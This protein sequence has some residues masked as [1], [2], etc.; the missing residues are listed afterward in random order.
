MPR[1]ARAALCGSGGKFRAME[2]SGMPVGGSLASS[3]AVAVDNAAAQQRNTAAKL[4]ARGFTSVRPLGPAVHSS[5]VSVLP[6]Q[7]KFSDPQYINRIQTTRDRKLAAPYQKSPMSDPDRQ[8]ARAFC[9]GRCTSAT[10]PRFE[11]PRY[12]VGSVRTYGRIST[13]ACMGSD[14]SET[15]T[16]PGGP[17]RILCSISIG[18]D[19]ALL[20]TY[21][22]SP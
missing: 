16:A 10:K 5:A 2:D 13:A 1:C 4:E 19:L 11:A 20:P 14:R 17:L 9:R 3:A 18:T 7:S 12:R 15:M 8:L 21:M 6:S 22:G